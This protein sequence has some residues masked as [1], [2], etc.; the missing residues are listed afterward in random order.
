MPD[1]LLREDRLPQATPPEHAVFENDKQGD[2]GTHRVDCS[3]DGCVVPRVGS[4]GADYL[5]SSFGNHLLRIC[6]L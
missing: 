4:F 1:T 6:A 3:D 2:R 5:L